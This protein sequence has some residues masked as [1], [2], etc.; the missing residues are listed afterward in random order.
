MACPPGSFSFCLW[1]ALRGCFCAVSVW[2]PSGAVIVRCRCVCP[3][4]VFLC[5]VPP[6]G[7]LCG[8][9]SG[10]FRVVCL[11]AVFCV[12]AFGRFKISRRV[13][14]AQGALLLCIFTGFP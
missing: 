13:E 11:R 4:G 10:V 1:G 8:V 12:R 6:G 14:S 2:V 5:G 3:W 7:F 9:P